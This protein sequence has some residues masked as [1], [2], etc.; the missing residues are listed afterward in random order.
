MKHLLPV[1]IALLLLVAQLGCTT[2]SN[3]NT[4]N[5]GNNSN[6]LPEQSAG[7]ETGNTGGGGPTSGETFGPN[8]NCTGSRTVFV[9]VNSNVLISLDNGN[10]ELKTPDANGYMEIPCTASY[11]IY[12]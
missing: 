3:T 12:R 10:Q 7:S 2:D 9:G 5:I 6:A 8:P 11:T 1:L 4:G